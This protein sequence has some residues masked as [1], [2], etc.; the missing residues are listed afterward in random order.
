MLAR[1]GDAFLFELQARIRD[2]YPEY[3]F[4]ILGQLIELRRMSP[5]S[6]EYSFVDFPPLLEERRQ[7]VQDKFGEISMTTEDGVGWF[8]PLRWEQLSEA[9]RSMCKPKF[10][11]D[12]VKYFL[13]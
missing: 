3:Q 4:F 6:A 12:N 7:W 11:K 2:E 1:E 9:Q 8:A 10:I 13:M 5:F